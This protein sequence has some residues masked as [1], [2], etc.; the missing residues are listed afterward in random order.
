[1]FDV[2]TAKP[3]PKFVTFYSCKYIIVEMH[4]LSK[5]S[6]IFFTII[7]KEK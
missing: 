5:K 3:D 7:I 6:Y 4:H 1:M 2:I